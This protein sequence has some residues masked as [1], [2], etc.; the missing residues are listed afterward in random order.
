[1]SSTPARPCSIGSLQIS[2]MRSWWTPDA[3]FLSGLLRE[4]VVAVAAEC[5]AAKHLN[6]FNGWTKKQLVEELASYFRERSDSERS[7]G[8]D[9]AAAR[10]WLPGVFRFP[11]LKTVTAAPAAS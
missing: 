3:A 8:E 5:G 4:Q 7:D 1:M 6:G 2:V 11:A 9:E 10:E